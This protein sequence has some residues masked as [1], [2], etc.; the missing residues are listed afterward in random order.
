MKQ[1]IVGF[2]VAVMLFLVVAPLALTLITLRFIL[3]FWAVILDETL[4]FLDEFADYIKE[5][6]A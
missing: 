6:D 5:R 2:G 4:L 3:S 1:L